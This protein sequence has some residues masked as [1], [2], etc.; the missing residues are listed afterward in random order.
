VPS[1]LTVWSVARTAIILLLGV[2]ELAWLTPWAYILATVISSSARIGD[3]KGMAQGPTTPLVP[4]GLIAS[5]LGLAWAV[6]TIVRRQQSRLV[7]IYEQPTLR[8]L[9][10][11]VTLCAIVSVAVV[12]LNLL[13]VPPGAPN[14]TTWIGSLTGG[15]ETGALLI[16]IVF[17]ALIWWRGTILGGAVPGDRE[18]GRRS[19]T[20]AVLIAISSGVARAVLP[21]LITDLLPVVAII[22][23]PAMLVAIALSSLEE[24]QLPR[25]GQPT[26]T[27]APD[28]NWI[29]MVAAMCLTVVVMGIILATVFGGG[30]SVVTTLLKSL[31]QAIAV[32]IVFA[33]SFVAIPFLMLAEWLAKMMGSV[34]MER[35]PVEMGKFGRP[36]P[37]D[38]VEQP[39]D[40]QL[41]DS[42][43]IEAGLAVVALIIIAIIVWRLL[44]PSRVDDLDGALDEERSTVFSWRS[45]FNKRARHTAEGAVEPVSDPVRVAYRKFQSLMEQHGSGRPSN[46]TARAFQIRLEAPSVGGAPRERDAGFPLPQTVNDAIQSLTSAYEDTRYGAAV[47]GAQSIA[48]DA[49]K[50]I[51]SGLRTHPTP[52]K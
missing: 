27:R 26:A 50:V 45:L 11:V 24:A 16:A 6:R 36:N 7:S 47:Q 51:E 18:A 4:I 46:E 49:I 44:R 39:G 17:S 31:G 48:D 12:S 41:L 19:T 20:S 38:Q 3:I 34:K 21:W 32:V 1:T 35:P 10:V 23:V 42:S 2:I 9:A 29:G 5:V 33:L 13:A 30:T 52:H 37:M 14:P 28:R 43:F 40:P 22:A 25:P 8:R 15:H